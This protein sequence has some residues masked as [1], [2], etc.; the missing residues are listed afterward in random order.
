MRFG[1]RKAWGSNAGSLRF[2]PTDEA[3]TTRSTWASS[4]A[5]AAFSCG[6]AARRSA[7]PR[8]R[9]ERK[10]GA[11]S[12]ASARG[13]LDGAVHEHEALAMLEGALDGDGA[14]CAA[15]RAEDHHAEVAD[16]A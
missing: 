5:R 7:G 15:T 2:M 12:A 8:R 9:S 4:A 13:F 1:V 16:I 14:A 6:M 3:F 10:W 11:S